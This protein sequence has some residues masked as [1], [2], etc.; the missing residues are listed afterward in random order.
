M[1]KFPRFTATT[2]A[3][4]PGAAR[5]TDIGSLVRTGGQAVWRGVSR[6]AKGIGSA[7][8]TLFEIEQHKQEMA[9]KQDVSNAI[10]GG[11]EGVVS[12]EAA[13]KPMVMESPDH[14]KEIT[15]QFTAGHEDY[16]NNIINQHKSAET[17][18]QLEIIKNEAVP[19]YRELFTRLTNG[20][21]ER[22]YAVTEEELAEAQV[23]EGDIE[24]ALA[25]MDALEKDDIKSPQWVQTKKQDFIKRHH[26]NTAL[27]QRDEET[28]FIDTD[29]AR[30]YINAT[31]LPK[32][33]KR[34]LIRKVDEWNNREIRKS[35]ENRDAVERQSF[36]EGWK[37]VL[38]DNLESEWVEK[39][40]PNLSEANAVRFTNIVEKNAAIKI[41]DIAD[42]TER[43]LAVELYVDKTLTKDILD[44]YLRDGT[45]DATQ[46]G[47]YLTNLRNEGKI[48]D[49]KE[50]FN[51]KDRILL[52]KA[53]RDDAKK[54]DEAIQTAFFEKKS[55][56]SAQAN[57]LRT[58]LQTEMEETDAV[59]LKSAYDYMYSAI[60][61]D[62]GLFFAGDN[63]AKKLYQKAQIE[64]FTAIQ[65]SKGTPK[66]ISGESIFEKG[67]KI[68][69]KYAK[70]PAEHTL[71]QMDSMSQYKDDIKKGADKRLKNKES[72]KDKIGNFLKNFA[73]SRK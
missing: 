7:A 8:D 44:G 10:K 3:R 67:K 50:Y 39:N 68:G 71:D 59:F 36:E 20:K 53:G 60:V 56:Q 51:L 4:G 35:A 43:K 66:E 9:R 70:T 46:Y 25:R 52:A 64:L 34:D 62:V 72:G 42:K 41:G 69:D 58:L 48:T 11:K 27:L 31:D 37:L 15:N 47:N 22:K 13:L 5:A 26:L 49:W 24:G 17:R 73:E 30:K 6:L 57:E 33:D 45:V 29:E 54:V 65:K 63:E 18:S 40:L 28:G 16:W 21:W 23:A 2:T 14:A 1:A 55:I 61:P 19:F 32:E 12:D 38:E